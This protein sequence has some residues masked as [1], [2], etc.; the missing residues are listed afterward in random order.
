MEGWDVVPR[1]DQPA[2]NSERGY[3]ERR[4][5]QRSDAGRN[6]TT[7]DGNG[8]ELTALPKRRRPR[9]YRISLAWRRT[10]ATTGYWSCPRLSDSAIV[11]RV[12]VAGL[13]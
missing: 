4:V 6:T 8:A 9:T 5:F 11:F 1:A 12:Y 10:R 2:S 3:W 7:A 13:A